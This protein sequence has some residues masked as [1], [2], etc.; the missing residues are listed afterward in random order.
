MNPS[1]PNPPDPF[2]YTPELTPGS[3][4]VDPRESVIPRIPL[5]PF[6]DKL[7]YGRA[8][9]S[10]ED[11]PLLAFQFSVE[12]TEDPFGIL[13]FK[14]PIKGF[15]T[16]VSGLDVEWETAEYKSTNIL[17][18]PHSNFVPMRP[19]YN[20]ITLKRGVTDSEA[21]WLWHQLLALGAKPLLKCYVMITMYN[22]SYQEVAQWSV[23]RA[24]PSKISGPQL[25]SESSDFVIEE[26]TLVHGGVMRMYMNPLF[27]GLDIAMQLLL[28]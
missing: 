23:E 28:P 5:S 25:H 7:K 20:T 1:P 19:V 22:R 26:M 14:I 17:G 12:L 2:A 13:G 4:F 8:A 3:P 18:L 24:W 6:L 10:R 27:M 11:D 15:F 9:H 16:E 21:F